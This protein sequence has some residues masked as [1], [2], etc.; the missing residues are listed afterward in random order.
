MLKEEIFN[1]VKECITNYLESQG[2]NI[3]VEN[4]TALIGREAVTDSM[5]LV[6][7][8][9]DIESKFLENGYE[10]SLTS[11]K[12]MSAKNSPFRNIEALSNFIFEL[13]GTGNE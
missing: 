10:I 9:I 2:K 5:G 4:N 7:I 13:I 12:A 3:I 1:K 11:E 6:N 8:I